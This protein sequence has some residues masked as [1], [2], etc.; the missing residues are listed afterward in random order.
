M[1][2][3]TKEDRRSRRRRALP[4]PGQQGLNGNQVQGLWL[5]DK[6]P[7]KMHTLV[8]GVNP[9]V[10]SATIGHYFGGKNNL[11][12]KL[13]HHSGVWPS[14]LATEDDDRVVQAGFGFTDTCKRPTPGTNGLNQA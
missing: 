2:S 9:G 5:E 11:F 8:V 3:S 7:R 14:P 10:R 12:W 6:I 13:L 4:R 1:V